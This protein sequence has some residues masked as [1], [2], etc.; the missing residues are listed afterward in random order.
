M[1]VDFMADLMPWHSLCSTVF[2]PEAP[3]AA[4][5]HPEET[6]QKGC[7][8]RGGSEMKRF[9]KIMVAC[10]CS[11]YSP[12]V[13][14]LAAE[15]AK[16]LDAEMVIANVI[17]QRDVDMVAKALTGGYPHFTVEDYIE[18]QKADRTTFIENLV[19]E[20]DCS[21]R[22][23]RTV[24]RIGVPFQELIEAVG[25]EKAG[26]LVMGTKGRGNLAGV[27]LG[28]TAEKMFRRCPVPLLSVRV[29]DEER[30]I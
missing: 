13:M 30:K 19:K 12:K 8:K 21:D 15:M 10:D 9:Q 6:I 5:F 1:V 4:V 7:R 24:F 25:T 14:S 3:G 27:L 29:K 18:N 28:S 22:H 23:V 16:A 26:L 2:R 17:N 20:A 11:L